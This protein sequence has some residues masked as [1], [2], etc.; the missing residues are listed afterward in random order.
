MM[1]SLRAKATEAVGNQKT[2]WADAMIPVAEGLLAH[3]RSEWPMA[4]ERLRAATSRLNLV[5][6]SNVQR[7]L[8]VAL[9]DDAQRRAEG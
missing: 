9:R 7:G 5:G 4:A 3:A 1:A 6:G 8:F 2:V